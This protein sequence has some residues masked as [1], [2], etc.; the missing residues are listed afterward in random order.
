MRRTAR[1]AYIAFI[2]LLAFGLSATAYAAYS[3][4]V[5]VTGTMTL[6]ESGTS[7]VVPAAGAMAAQEQFVMVGETPT[8]VP[9]P[10]Q[11]ATAAPTPTSDAASPIATPDA[12]SPTPTPDAATPT[13]DA[14]ETGAQAEPPASSGVE[15]AE[16]E[17]SA[18]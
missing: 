4:T 12:A 6:R 14:T 5:T 15:S 17:G 2:A 3:R 7:G 16:G 9:T 1:I 13:P 18:S 8:P 11:D 10:P